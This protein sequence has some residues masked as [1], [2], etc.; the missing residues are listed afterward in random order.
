MLSLVSLLGA[1]TVDDGVDSEV[2]HLT[3]DLTLSL[4]ISVNQRVD[5]PAGHGGVVTSGDR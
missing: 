3:I 4:D 2:G 1:V 5:G